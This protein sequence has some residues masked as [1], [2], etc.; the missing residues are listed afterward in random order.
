MKFKKAIGLIIL[1]LPFT[2][3]LK[4]QMKEGYKAE[5]EVQAIGTTNGTVPFWMRSNQ[6]GSVPLNGV[7][8]S[9]IGRL[10]KD[11]AELSTSDKLY[12]RKK[13]FDWGFGFEGRANGGKNSNLQ[14]IEGYVKAKASIFQLKAGRSKDI[15][16]FNGDTLLSSGNF[17][18]SGN[19]LGI[20]KVELSIP[21]Y[22]RLPILGGILS[23][24]GNFSH[25]WIGNM[26]TNPLTA[27]IEGQSDTLQ[28]N[29]YSYL[30][31]KSFYGR[32]GKK[33]WKL[34]LFGGFSHQG[35][36]G[37]EDKMYGN[38]YTLSKVETFMYVAIGKAYHAKGIPGSKIGNQLGS[39]DLGAEYKFNSF[40]L[41]IY[42]QFFYDIGGLYHLNNLRDGLNGVSLTN[43][44]YIDLSDSFQWKN[45]LFEFFYSYN[46]GGEIWSKPS[47]SGAEDYYNNYFYQQGWSYRGEA[48]GSPLITP[49]HYARNGQS[50][51]TK[52][53]FINN[54][55]IAFHS[56][57]KGTYKGWD[58]TIKLT[59]S[60][61]YG[62][63]GTSPASRSLGSR[64]VFRTTN[65]FKKVEQLT[66]S[67]E[68]GKVLERNYYFS[69]L[70]AIDNGKLLNNSFGFQLRLKKSFN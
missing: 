15:M 31:Q 62:T 58:N 51:E 45:L 10:S 69:V 3:N 44:R 35:T 60:L 50:S 68:V 17:A 12:G 40:N 67:F 47:P 64:L 55:V 29:L 30:H 6:F 26:R 19:A 63:F 61:N 49:K 2:V 57:Y 70:A 7:S 13:V 24:K 8:G 59:Y 43:N 38:L 66:T 36:W 21:E 53:Y 33:E 4:A 9:V 48:L 32:V 54:R 18:V 39:I 28:Y 11:Y 46:Q 22:Y 1:S 20:P 14:L 34:N 42:R 41:K 16:G 52:S 27:I 65:L 25:G 23:I 56:G 5:V 37:G